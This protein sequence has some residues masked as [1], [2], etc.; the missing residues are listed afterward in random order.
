[1][2]ILTSNKKKRKKKK[3]RINT[4][5]IKFLFANKEKKKKKGL[6]ID[7]VGTDNAKMRVIN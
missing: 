1:M 4:R 2:N 7:K 3:K 5:S 6:V